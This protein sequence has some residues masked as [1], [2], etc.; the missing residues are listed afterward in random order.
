[1]DAIIITMCLLQFDRIIIEIIYEKV[2][3]ET[4]E[5]FLKILCYCLVKKLF[6]KYLN[7]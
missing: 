5:I 6:H 3:R 7:T 4:R 2:I 1:M